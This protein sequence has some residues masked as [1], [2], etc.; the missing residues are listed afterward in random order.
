[1]SYGMEVW[2]PAKR[3]ANMTS[4]LTWAAKLVRGI[5]RDALHT[6]FFMDRSVN[7]DVMLADLDVLWADDHCRTAHARQYARQTAATTAAA[8]YARHDPCSPGFDVELSAAYAP[9]YMGA[10]VWSG[11]HTRDGWHN[12]ARTCHDTALSHCVHPEAA[13]THTVPVMVGGSER[14]TCKDIRS[15][16]SA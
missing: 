12:F 6:A 2:Q 11:L 1:M 8:L 16:I 3:G 7:Q 14:A 4:V 15:G 5:C 9:D 13:P 10:A